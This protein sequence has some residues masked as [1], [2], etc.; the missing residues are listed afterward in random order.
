MITNLKIQNVALINE[1][2]INFSDGLN[3]LTGETG[4]GKSILVDSINFLLGGRLGRDF[5]RQGADFAHVEGIVEFDLNNEYVK[6]GLTTIGVEYEDGQLM[7]ERRLMASSGKSVC[8]INGRT[9]TAAILKE[10]A[11]LF[12]ALHGQHEHQSLLDPSKQMILLDSFC[13]EGLENQ[14]AK[15]EALLGKYKKVNKNLKALAGIGNQRQE[16]IDVWHF[17]LDE[18]NKAAVKLNEEENLTNKKNRLSGLEKLSKNT[19]AA[20]N[21]LDGSTNEGVLSATD[22]TSRAVTLL[23]EVVKIDSSKVELYERLVETLAGLTDISQELSG[24][25]GELDADPDELEKI[26]ARLDVI[27]RLRKKYGPSIEAV[28]KKQEELTKNI[29][30]IENSEEE[31]KNLQ[32]KKRAI[33]KDITTMCDKINKLRTRHADVISKKITEILQ[34]LGMQNAKF[35]IEVTRKT[36]FTPDGNDLVEFMI[37]PN[38]GESIKPLRKIA[39][40]GE[41]SRVMLAIKTVIADS[42]STVI[43][44]EVDTG[45]SGR[46][47]QQVAEKLKGLSGKRQILCITHLPQIAAMANTHFLIEKS[48]DKVK[49][50]VRTTTSVEVLNKEAAVNELARLIGGAQITN[51]TIGAA[52]EMKEQAE[53]I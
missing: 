8:R 33:I 36:S 12:V 16:Q 26:E 4:A 49:G 31:I 13:G 40:G 50:V 47:A 52:K 35:A 11:A 1:V 41:M 53:G 45:I 20:L 5:I 30:S 28:F 44:D 19:A 32:S 2:E 25:F 9:V 48:T 21:F 15:L 24:Y 39:S 34:D 37:S 51:A 14:K 23:S 3:I 43:F 29:N 17:Q 18:I 46:T 22:Q 7:M 27:Y 42:V 10:A 6:N 38:Q